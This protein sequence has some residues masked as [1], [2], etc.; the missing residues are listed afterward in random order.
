[1]INVTPLDEDAF[2]EEDEHANAGQKIAKSFL[3]SRRYSTS[4]VK[5]RQERIQELLAKKQAQSNQDKG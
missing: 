4:W 2:P 3:P 5:A 1:V